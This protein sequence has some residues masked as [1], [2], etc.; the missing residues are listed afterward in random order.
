MSII[1]QRNWRWCSKCQGLWYSAASFNTDGKCPAGGTHSKAGS[2]DYALFGDPDGSFSK[3]VWAQTRWRWC[4]KCQG[5]WYSGASFNTDG[6]CA[7]GGT[8]EK[9]GSGD[10]G[11]FVDPSGN[12]PTGTPTLNG[13][14]FWRW[15]SKCQGLWYSA[16]SVNHDGV[17]PGGGH[18][19]KAASGD[20][21]LMLDADGNFAD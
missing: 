16:A 15:C 21:A 20:Y 19:E 14:H 8:H 4:S 7:A 18:H 3:T 10:Y 2:G 5:L 6:K 13:Q 17:C 9:A 1:A 11:L 12:A